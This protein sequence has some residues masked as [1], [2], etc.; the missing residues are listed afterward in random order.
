MIQPE[1]FQCAAKMQLL[2]QK[3]QQSVVPLL[4]G[5]VLPDG[6]QIKQRHAGALFP[7]TLRSAHHKRR[8][9]DLTR[10]EDVAEFAFEQM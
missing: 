8:F 2:A 6:S 1:I 3:R 5:D 9:A 10:V 7:Q 4:D